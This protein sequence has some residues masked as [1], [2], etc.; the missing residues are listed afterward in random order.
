[1]CRKSAVI[2]IVIVI[3]KAVGIALLPTPAAPI[4]GALIF[5]P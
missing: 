5:T 1:M 3:K 4:G 2:I